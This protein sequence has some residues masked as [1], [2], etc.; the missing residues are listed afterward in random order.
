MET[1]L[2][3]P[4]DKGGLTRLLYLINEGVNAGKFLPRAIGFTALFSG[5]VAIVGCAITGIFV[6]PWILFGM[7]PGLLFWYSVAHQYAV[8]NSFNPGLP[9]K[10]AQNALD[11]IRGTDA[12]SIALP[13]AVNVYKH[14]VQEHSNSYVTSCNYCVTRV[15]LLNN[16]VP[17]ISEATTDNSDVESAKIYIESHE[18]IRS[19]A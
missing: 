9:Y 4:P 17:T 13:L 8:G 16:L 2:F 6:S 5:S 7:L 11:K 1:V 18:E 10:S 15:N 12:E 14:C 19:I 3:I